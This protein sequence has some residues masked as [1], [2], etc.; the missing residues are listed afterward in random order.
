MINLEAKYKAMQAG[1]EARM[2]DLPITDNPHVRGDKRR[3][4]WSQGWQ[5]ADRAKLKV[6]REGKPK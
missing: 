1:Y 5:E 4:A 3:R 2:H 6:K